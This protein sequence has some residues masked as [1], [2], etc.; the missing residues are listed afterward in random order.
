MLNNSVTLNSCMSSFDI[1]T[2]DIFLPI[3]DS[4]IEPQAVVNSS[5]DSLLGI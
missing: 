5:I 1:D 2:S 3:I 4:P